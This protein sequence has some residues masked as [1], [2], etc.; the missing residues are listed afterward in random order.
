M[1]FDIKKL[2]RVSADI[3]ADCPKV[4]FYLTT[5][6]ITTA[7]YFPSDCGMKGGDLVSV[8]NI[9]KSSGAVTAVTKKDYYLKSDASGVLTATALAAGA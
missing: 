5:D 1:A 7:G 8:I 9:T 3:V 2:S 6:T 4:Y